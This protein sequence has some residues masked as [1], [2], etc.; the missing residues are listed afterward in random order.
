MSL[1]QSSRHATLAVRTSPSIQNG[2]PGTL[3][4]TSLQW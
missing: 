1:A 4:G 2:L 3:Q